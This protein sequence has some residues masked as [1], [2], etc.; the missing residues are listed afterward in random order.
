MRNMIRRIKRKE[1]VE[2]TW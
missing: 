1:Q 2:D